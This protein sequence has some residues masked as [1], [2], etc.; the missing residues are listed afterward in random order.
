M[1]SRHDA[2]V[3]RRD[4]ALPGLATLLDPEAFLAALR[5]G[6]PAAPPF[7]GTLRAAQITYV[8]YKPGTNCLV[9]YRLDAAG[10]PVEVNA[11]AYRPDARG[12][13]QQARAR[14]A[15]AGALGA[16]GIVLEAGTIV[17]SVFPDD[18]KLAAL[19]QLVEADARRGLLC[20]LL[21]DRPDLWDGTVR[22][23][24]YKPE[25][26][27]VAQVLAGGEARAVLRV[28][29][30]PGYRAA[31]GNGT[32]LASR[33][34]LRL[35]RRLGRSDRLCSLAFEW[36][37]GHSL[38]EAL[39]D[40]ARGPRSVAA[41]GAAL[42]ELHGQDPQGLASLTRQAEAATLQA[43]AAGLAVVCPGLAGR[44]ERLAGR[45]AARLVDE[46]AVDRPIHGDFYPQQVLLT[47]GRVA[48]LDLDEAVR[49]D[50][51]ADLGLFI[52]HL[53]D[54]ALRGQLA[55]GRVEALG[56]ALL[57]GYRLAAHPPVPAQVELYAAA[58]LVRLAPHCFRRRHPDW[59]A[60]TEAMLER[61]EALLNRIPTG[62]LS[63]AHAAP[64]PAHRPQPPAPLLPASP[65]TDSGLADRTP[66]H[67]GPYAVR[68]AEG[69]G[70]DR[71]ARR[72]Q[73]R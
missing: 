57:A 28:Y 21:P 27:Y 63:A 65:S 70:A 8:K 7:A 29:A 66:S 64:R 2:D 5:P 42:A 48:I 43:V 49:G 12:A 25:R 60:R 37:P 18:G 9:G 14:P 20:E 31:R 36:L 22:R 15:V 17:V 6:R 23:L 61:A 39:A 50:P 51:A 32:A 33:G 4:P 55:G 38:S 13:L 34:R 67:A 56:D 58:G 19:P 68:P 53:E 73:A 1:L 41:A 35:A 52:A 26:R 3:V 54:A 10:G 30:A 11:T 40:P 16:G 71:A 47:D 44:A 62:S 72:G 59:P 24:T 45:L 69:T 46:P